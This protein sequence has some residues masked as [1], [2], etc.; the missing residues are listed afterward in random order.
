MPKLAFSGRCQLWQFQ[1]VA[2]FGSFRKL[3]T[4]AEVTVPGVAKIDNF[5]TYWNLPKVAL[6]H[7]S[8]GRPEPFLSAYRHLVLA[9]SSKIKVMCHSCIFI[10]FLIECR[11]IAKWRA[12]AKLLNLYVVLLECLLCCVLICKMGYSYQIVKKHA[13]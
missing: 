11:V 12:A 9:V 5:W 10:W 7:S 4:L 3:P 2:N 8:H 13:L 1:G 6:E